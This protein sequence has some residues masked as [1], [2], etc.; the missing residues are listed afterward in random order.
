MFLAAS[1]V[2]Q[3]PPPAGSSYRGVDAGDPRRSKPPITL[4]QIRSI[5]GTHVRGEQDGSRPTAPG[6]AQAQDARRSGQLR[7]V[8]KEMSDM[9]RHSEYARHETDMVDLLI[10]AQ[11]APKEHDP[12]GELADMNGDQPDGPPAGGA[13]LPPGGFGQPAPAAALGRSPRSG[14]ARRRAARCSRPPS[15]RRRVCL[16]VFCIHLTTIPARA[17]ARQIRPRA[18]RHP[19]LVPEAL[20]RP[21]GS[22]APHAG[23]QR[24]WRVAHA[25]PAATPVG[26]GASRSRQV[27]V[28]PCGALAF[29]TIGSQHVC[30]HG[31]GAS[32]IG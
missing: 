4:Q 19:H 7:N 27:G 25:G 1:L 13:P 16:R 24:R 9:F 8:R 30:Q 15:A 14:A 26:L 32:F 17:A 29:A 5:A 12:E 3:Q 23:E 2:A 6:A 21:R 18:A 28:R 31:I 22:G 11:L 20:D 10:G